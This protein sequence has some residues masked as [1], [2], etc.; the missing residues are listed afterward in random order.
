M[1]KNTDTIPWRGI[2]ITF[3]RPFENNVPYHMQFDIT[4]DTLYDIIKWDTYLLY[5]EFTEAGRIHYHGKYKVTDKTKHLKTIADLRYQCGL[6]KLEEIKYHDKWNAYI[7]KEILETSRLV[8]RV[9]IEL[10]EI[11]RH[12]HIMHKQTLFLATISAFE[13]GVLDN[14]IL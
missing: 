2:T 1:P 4:R 9:N 11:N 14:I 10:N 13:K 3:K 6:I 7:R 12:K 8:K 5:P